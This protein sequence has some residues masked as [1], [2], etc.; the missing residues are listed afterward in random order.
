LAHIPAV[1]V[2]KST[3]NRHRPSPEGRVPV[4]LNSS[5]LSAFTCPSRP[6]KSLSL[7]S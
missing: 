7:A 3:Q 6:T 1:A 4:W 2:G 5:S